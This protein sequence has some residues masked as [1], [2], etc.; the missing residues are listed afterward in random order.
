MNKIFLLGNVGQDPELRHTGGGT[1]VL[2]IRMATSETYRDKQTGEKKETTE[3]HS[4]CIWDKRA[5]ALSKFI[6]K[7]SKILVEGSLQTR[8]WEKDGEKRYSTEV[9]AF[10]IELLDKKPDTGG[11][12]QQQPQGGGSGWGD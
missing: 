10:N 8:S 6:R 7:G 1:A 2:N 12:Q 3:W 9:K 4:V 5:E 11:G